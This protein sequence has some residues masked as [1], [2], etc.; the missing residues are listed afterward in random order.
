MLSANCEPELVVFG[1]AFPAQKDR[2]LAAPGRVGNHGGIDQKLHV[3][4]LGDRFFADEEAG[5]DNGTRSAGG[6]VE[7]LHDDEV[8]VWVHS[9]F[10]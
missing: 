2:E 3:V 10:R 1:Q 4:D 5:L 8:G 9:G 7:V 6:D